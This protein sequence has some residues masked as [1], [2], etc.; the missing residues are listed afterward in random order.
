MLKRQSK[1][2]LG[3]E[4]TIKGKEEHYSAIILQSREVINQKNEIFN[5]HLIATN[6][7][8]NEL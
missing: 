2:H 3:Q 8:Y 4:E 1:S 7:S 6:N 5:S